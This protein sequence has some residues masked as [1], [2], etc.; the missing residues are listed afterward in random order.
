MDQQNLNRQNR[1]AVR[2]DESIVA[3]ESE[4]I[5]KFFKAL[6]VLVVFFSSFSVPIYLSYKTQEKAKEMRVKMEMGQLRNWAMIYELENKDYDGLDNNV[7]IKKV[8][9]SIK[10]MGGNAYIFVSADHKR[11]CCQTNFLNKSLGSWCVDY[12]GNIGRD[13]NCDKNNVQCK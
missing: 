4:K 7:E 1:D 9:E 10:S 5:K 2:T 12:T 11:Y 8:F 3:G 13:G 6:A